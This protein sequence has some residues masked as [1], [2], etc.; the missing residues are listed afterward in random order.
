M[1][2]KLKRGVKPPKTSQKVTGV[3][4]VHGQN[5]GCDTGASFIISF[6]QSLN[7]PIKNK[8]IRGCVICQN[9][10]ISDVVDP[11]LFGAEMSHKDLKEK[12][13]VQYGYMVELTEIKAHARHIYFEKDE[14]RETRINEYNVVKELPTIDIINEELAQ[15]NVDIKLARNEG[16]DNTIEFSKLLKMK[17]DL[18][19]LKAKIEGDIT[20]GTIVVPAWLERMEDEKDRHKTIESG[21]CNEDTCN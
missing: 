5:H 14:E 20:D 4:E 1:S 9:R 17:L 18:L 6:H 3:H 8:N 13:Q 12:L 11:I 19:N 15:V 21:N 2:E 10:S 16:R 7:M